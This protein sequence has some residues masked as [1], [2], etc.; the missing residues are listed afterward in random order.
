MSGLWVNSVVNWVSLSVIG[1]INSEK[2]YSFVI[3]LVFS[4]L[5]LTRCPYI[6]NYTWFILFLFLF[7]IPLYIS[8]VFTRLY[9]SF[10][11]FFAEMI[12]SGSPLWILPFIPHIEMISFLIRPVVLLLRPF[13]NISVGIYAGLTI[14]DLFILSDN[15]T[16]MFFLFI[17]FIYEVF[18]I[19]VHWFIINE[20]LKFTVFH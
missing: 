4:E 12:P 13:I 17:F 3:L 20:I 19:V 1:G 7:I 14:G 6:Y 16:F 9:S 15:Y 8:L 10:S 5:V 2:W 11:K 18:V